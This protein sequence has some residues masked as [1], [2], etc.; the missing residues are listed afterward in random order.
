[1]QYSCFLQNQTV[2]QPNSAFLLSEQSLLPF[3][4]KKKPPNKNHKQQQQLDYYDHETLPKEKASGSLVSQ[5]K[6]RHIPH[7]PLYSK[8]AWG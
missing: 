8:W 5:R 1:M 3:R 4:K 2:M 7:F 6:E